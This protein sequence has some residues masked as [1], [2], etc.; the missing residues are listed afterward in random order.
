MMGG[1]EGWGQVDGSLK[2]EMEPEKETERENEKW[3][4]E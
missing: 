2:R 3:K 1:E 4:R